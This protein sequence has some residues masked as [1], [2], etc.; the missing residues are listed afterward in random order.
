[1]NSET[2]NTIFA[3]NS[4]PT[5]VIQA[6]YTFESGSGCLIFNDYYPTGEQAHNGDVTS[7]V[8]ETSPAVSI[9]C[10][11]NVVN[12]L[13]TSSGIF[14]ETDVLEVVQPIATGNW[15]FFVDYNE[16]T[17]TLGNV[18]RVMVS[19]MDQ[20]SSGSGFNFG[21]N[22]S[23]RAYFEYID[24]N[25][26][27]QIYT[28]PQDVGINNLV[29][30]SQSSNTVSITN[31]DIGSFEHET[32]QFELS[33]F[34]EADTLY[35]G[36]FKTG[37]N[38]GYQGFSG[39]MDS[40]ILFNESLTVDNQNTIAENYFYSGIQ[41]GSRTSTVVSGLEVTGV[42][43]NLSGLTGT[44]ITG[45]V[46]ALYKTV[47]SCLCGDINFYRDSGVSG[48]LFGQVVTYLTGSGYVTGLNFTDNPATRIN[49]YDKSLKYAEK[50][51]TFLN[52]VPAE[53]TYELYSFSTFHGDA[54]NS[55]A[56]YKGGVDY[57]YTNTG[58]QSGN[59]NVFVNGLAKYSG[60]DFTIITSDLDEKNISFT[61]SIFNSTDNVTFDRISGSQEAVSSF[62]GFAVTGLAL[63]HSGSGYTS[64]PSVIFVGGEN[65]A[66]TAVTGDVGGVTRVTNLIL[67]SGGSGHVIA[68]T[69]SITGG[70]AD[71]NASGQAFIDQNN[72]LL[73]TSNTDDPY[74]NGYKL[75]SGVDY[76][77]TASAITLISSQVQKSKYATGDVIFLPRINNN[78][79]HVTGS[80]AQF[81]NTQTALVEEQ[82]WLNGQRM[83]RDE[84]YIR[85]S[86]ISLLKSPSF[87]TGFDNIIYNNDNDFFNT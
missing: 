42:S 51:I 80:A 34:V 46:S 72:Y 10:S 24:S 40:F 69:V 15:T 58:Y 37:V 67:T 76:T 48:E 14:K 55:Q 62:S 32:E 57:F 26:I 44:G 87:I 66:A 53:S 4:L 52:K 70:G 73:S 38:A 8:L 3:I 22:A 75:L 85:V 7:P 33:N 83:L 49:D 41:Q 13:N 23:N 27:K 18:A 79:T 9:S 6:V 39:N 19:T 17:D 81:V 25:N 78:F 56:Q 16:S 65:T 47:E 1:M 61:P 11:A 29:S 54:L 30:V 28:H 35:I 60:T 63:T 84:D 43:V 74:L 50:G 59:L 31:H 5:G 12:N 82:V 21:F 36:N 2:L 20:S 68:P 45:Y 64:V 71:I 86:N 77:Q